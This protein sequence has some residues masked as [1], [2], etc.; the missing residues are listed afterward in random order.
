MR[1]K[2]ASN[3]VKVVLAGSGGDELFAGYPWRYYRAVKCKNF[4]EYIDNYY[5]YWQRL[6]KDDEIREF[7]KPVYDEIKSYPTKN[8]FKNIFR[9][10]SH[11]DISPQ[12]SVNYSLYLEAKDIFARSFDCRGQA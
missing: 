12:Q 9:N 3:F 8:V 6:L 7:F 4:D 11:N 5:E 2:L 10:I 1:Q